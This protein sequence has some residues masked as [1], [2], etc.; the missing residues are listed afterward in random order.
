MAVDLK[1]QLDR[2]SVKAQIITQR[3]ITLTR[4]LDQANAEIARLSETIGRMQNEIE[5]LKLANEYLRM[6][7]TL[8]HDPAEVRKAKAIITGLVRDIDRCIRDLND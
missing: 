7:K 1:Q 2:V 5:K 8:A 3:Y 4:Q 6:V